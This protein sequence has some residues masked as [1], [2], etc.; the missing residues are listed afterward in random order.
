MAISA[1]GSNTD[2]P[3]D[4]TEVTFA[5]R[6][7]VLHFYLFEVLLSDKYKSYNYYDLKY[8]KKI[9]WNCLK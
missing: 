1:A 8:N 9:G 6:N 3:N 4:A 2:I 7:Y 5:I